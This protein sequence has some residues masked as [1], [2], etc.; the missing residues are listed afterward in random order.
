MGRLAGKIALIT[1]RGPR[2]RPAAPDLIDRLVATARQEDEVSN[3]LPHSP[4]EGWFSGQLRAVPFFPKSSL[5]WRAICA[6]L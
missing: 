2:H 3:L 1:A 5:R 4:D 6:R